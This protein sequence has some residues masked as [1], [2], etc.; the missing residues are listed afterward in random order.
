MPEATDANEVCYG[1][2]RMLATL[3]SRPDAGP[4]EVLKM[5]KDDIEAFVKDYE[6]FDDI[7]MMVFDYYGP[8]GVK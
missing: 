2:E 1:A 8:D 7:T 5:L 4:E 3:N 6:Q